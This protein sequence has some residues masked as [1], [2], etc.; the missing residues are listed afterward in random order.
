MLNVTPDSFSDGGEFAE[1]DAAIV[2]ARALIAAGADVLDIGAESTRPGSTG[3]TPTEQ[4]RRL[5]PV[6]E[7]LQGSIDVPVSIDTTSAEVAAACLDLGVDIV[8]DISAFRFDER[9]IDLLAE[10][11]VPHNTTR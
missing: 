4:L 3:V 10:R 9:M 8:N 1:A 11:G 5:V 6:L 2:Q 7:G